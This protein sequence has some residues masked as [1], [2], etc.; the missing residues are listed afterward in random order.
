[1]ARISYAATL[2]E[3]RTNHT[4]RAAVGRPNSELRKSHEDH[5]LE[6]AESMLV[7]PTPRQLRQVLARRRTIGGLAAELGLQ[8][9]EVGED[10]GLAPQFVGDHRR[11]ARNGRD[12]GNP[13]AAAL[14]RLDQRAEIAVAGTASSMSMLPLTLR[15]PLAS[16]NSLVALVTTV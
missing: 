4:Y 10:V 1:M 13:D 16:M 7:T 5:R 15:R 9:H 8:F 11:L 12:H 6:A 3:G 14:H 2:K